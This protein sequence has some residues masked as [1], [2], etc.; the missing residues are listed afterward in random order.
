M[1]EA[2][3][4]DG[5]LLRLEGI[6]VVHGRG[7]AS[8]FTALSIDRL[9]VAAGTS[10]G[11]AGPSGAGK[12][13]LLHL[14]AGLL[15]PSAGAVYWDGRRIDVGDEGTRD[16]FRRD[17][18]GFVFQDFHLVDELSVIENVL[19]P[20][21]FA[22]W[23]ADREMRARA[24]GLVEVVGLID[25]DRR[26]VDLSRGERQRVAVARALFGRPRLLIADEPTA[27][28]DAENG[29]AIAELLV[30]TAR[31]SE[32]TLLVAAHDRTLLDRLDRVI[33][34]AGGRIVEEK[35]R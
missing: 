14:V 24:R 28:L 8:P 6:E 29:A 26:A 23:R 22:T 34:L 12:S 10:L 21:R 35:T 1:S 4:G 33:T 27:S 18:I 25:P 11:I 3:D 17:T 19:L 5:K 7:A 20:A 13:T 32:A 2:P 30:T 9:E 15:G 31:E 16:R